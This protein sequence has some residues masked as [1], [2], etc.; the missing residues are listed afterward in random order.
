MSIQS[1][2]IKNIYEFINA[3]KN[4]C[5]DI[6]KWTDSGPMLKTYKILEEFYKC[7]ITYFFRGSELSTREYKKKYSLCVDEMWFWMSFWNGAHKEWA[8]N[9]LNDIIKCYAYCDYL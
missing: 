1:E 2:Y 6:K 5:A 3:K 7:S 9:Q 8:E 4:I